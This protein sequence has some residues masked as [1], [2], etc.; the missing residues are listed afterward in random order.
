MSIWCFFYVCVCE[1]EGLRDS[2]FLRQFHGNHDTQPV[3]LGHPNFQTKP[4]LK[5]SSCEIH[6]ASREFASCPSPAV[7]SMDSVND[8][9]HM[10]TGE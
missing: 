1:T 8:D 10:F 6:G 5:N 3:D 4:H 7:W 2:P 9:Y